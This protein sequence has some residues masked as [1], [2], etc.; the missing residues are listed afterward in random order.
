MGRSKADLDNRSKQLNPERN[1][2][3]QS[4]GEE[5]RPEDWEE[6]KQEPQD[7]SSS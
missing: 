1:E 6:Q 7:E 3:W 5:E 4:R 2:Y